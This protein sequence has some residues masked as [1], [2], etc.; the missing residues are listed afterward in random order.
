MIHDQPPEQSPA[1]QPA[2][3]S[4]RLL[5][6]VTLA[7]ICA[8]LDLYPTQPLLPYLKSEFHAT[9]WQVGLTV[10]A[11]TIAV[12]LAA[13][14]I[15]LL[16]DA[17]GRK[18]VIVS[19]IF[20]LS[21]PT[22]LAATSA[23]LRQL[24]FWRF[25]QGLFLPGIFAITIAYISEEVHPSRVG[26]TMAIYVTG[27]VIGGFC[28]RF[29]AGLV[30][31]HHGW[32]AV[33]L[34]L[35]SL[36]FAGGF[37]AWTALPPAQHFVRQTD[38]G[39]SIRAFGSHL[40]NRRLIAT[41]AAGFNVLFSLV[42][43][44]TYINFYLA[45]PPFRLG[46]AQLGSIFFVYLVG[47]VVTPIASRWIDR[48]GYRTTFGLAVCLASSGVS[49]T[50]VPVLWVVIA[51]LAVCSTGIFICQSAAS[52]HVGAAAGRARSSA[53]GLYMS[54][55]YAGGT[56]GSIVPGLLWRTGGWPVCV[57]LIVTVQA[58]AATLALLF[59]L[60]PS[61]DEATALSVSQG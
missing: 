7:G 3:P 33:F 19:A 12:A 42:A 47:V 31:A 23:G 29:L 14:F 52:S 41:Y 30:A 59:W 36:T 21:V 56:V 60:P 15:G 2:A 9:E 39:A 10:G 4:P 53:A 5:L 61:E 40:R 18:R 24:I 57:A 48:L 16:A 51:G 46:T 34:T 26:S 50:L 11:T 17:V 49:L 45:A 55:Y 38:F 27:T 1:L 37:I 25:V 44:F 58:L 54:L 20:A 28:G 6:G 13:P 32:H 35:G 8:F 43:T 22:V